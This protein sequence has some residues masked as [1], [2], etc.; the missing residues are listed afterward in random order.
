MPKFSHELHCFSSW[1]QKPWSHPWPLSF[2]LS[3]SD[4][5][6]YL[7]G[8]TFKYFQNTT[9]SQ[10]FCC[11]QP[12]PCHHPL[13]WMTVRLPVFL[14]LPLPPTMFQT[15]QQKWSSYNLSQVISLLYSLSRDSQ[16]HVQRP[17]RPCL[18]HTRVHSDLLP[19]SLTHST[20]PLWTHRVY[21]HLRVTAL[22]IPLPGTLFPQ[23]PT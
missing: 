14:F 18:F 23:I 9:S 6:A 19:L 21:A 20:P 8:S 10:L 16:N 13:S 12:D 2:W 15:C 4:L 1:D 5:S 17:T 22:A 3:A 11:N 7:V